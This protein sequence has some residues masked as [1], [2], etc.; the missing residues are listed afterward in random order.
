MADTQT[1]T[2]QPM[3]LTTADIKVLLLENN[4]A[5][6]EDLTKAVD[7]RLLP[8]SEQA[9]SLAKNDGAQDA[10]IDQLKVRIWAVSA[11]VGAIAS[12]LGA[13]V[14]FIAANVMQ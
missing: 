4:K 13:F 3:P 2:V 14:G 12:G 8:F 9:I 5:F 7:S 11:S 6:A 10:K 1:S